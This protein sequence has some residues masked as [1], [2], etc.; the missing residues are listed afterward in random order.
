MP[1]VLLQPHL[2]LCYY[3]FCDVSVT[4]YNVRVTLLPALLKYILD[5]HPWSDSTE[6]RGCGRGSSDWMKICSDYKL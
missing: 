6:F 1:F 4:L 5:V 3:I 2:L